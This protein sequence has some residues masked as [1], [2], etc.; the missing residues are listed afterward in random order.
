MIVTSSTTEWTSPRH[1]A[2]IS[3][4]TLAQHLVSTQKTSSSTLKGRTWASNTGIRFPWSKEGIS[5]AAS[6]IWA[7]S[8][9]GQVLRWRS[10]RA[11]SPW[12]CILD[13][14]VSRLPARETCKLS[15]LKQRTSLTGSTTLPLVAR[16]QP[17]PAS[18]DAR[19]CE[20]TRAARLFARQLTSSSVN[21]YQRNYPYTWAGARIV[22]DI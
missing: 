9:N 10:M 20:Q 16:G 12:S 21:W 8:G 5:S 4:A 22:Q 6:R 13:I 15:A 18:R 3:T 17:I 7:V 2:L 14:Q 19:P 1:H 11:L